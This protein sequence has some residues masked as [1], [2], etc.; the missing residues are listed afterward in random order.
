MVPTIAEEEE[1]GEEKVV[2]E[3]E[4]EEEEAEEEEEEEAE[5]ED[6][7]ERDVVLLEAFNIYD[8][9]KLKGMSV[10]RPDFRCFRSWVL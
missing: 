6:A 5:E 9:R 4:E 1:E 8:L 2:A 10:R 7:L 3:E